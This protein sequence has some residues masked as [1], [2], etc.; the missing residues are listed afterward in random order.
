M[1]LSFW[2]YRISELV[3]MKTHSSGDTYEYMNNSKMV[4]KDKH[5]LKTMSK[6]P[7]TN[8]KLFILLN[9]ADNLSP[10]KTVL[11]ISGKLQED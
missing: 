6:H 7:M 2:Y 8:L 5:S 3:D 9:R 10:D 11:E 4:A 1:F